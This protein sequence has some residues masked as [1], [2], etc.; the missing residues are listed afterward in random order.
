M[1]KRQ[2][3][4]LFTAKHGTYPSYFHIDVESQLFPYLHQLGLEWGWADPS[5]RFSNYM[6]FI[7]LR[8]ACLLYTSR[9][10]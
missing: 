8:K 7:G 3:L 2:G 9:C 6:G 1:Y 10:V 5:Q 4:V